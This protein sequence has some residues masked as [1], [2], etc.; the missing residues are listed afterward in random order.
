MRLSRADKLEIA[1]AS[2]LKVRDVSKLQVCPGPRGADTTRHGVRCRGRHLHWYIGEFQRRP[3]ISG[4]VQCEEVPTFRTE[5]EARQFLNAVQSA[6]T[7][8]NA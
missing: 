8:A 2:L 1:M 3:G 6:A 7:G 4:A 5:R